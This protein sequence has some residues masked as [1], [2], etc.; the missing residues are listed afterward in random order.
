LAQHPT[1]HPEQD[2]VQDAERW[3]CRIDGVRQCKIDL[4]RHG[5]VAAIHVVA[6]KSREPRHIV[7]D[8]E[9]LLK[10]R[11]DLNVYYKKIGVVQVLD[12]DDLPEAEPAAAEP[13]VEPRVVPAVPPEAVTEEEATRRLSAAAGGAVAAAGN[14]GS[15]AEPDAAAPGP[16]PR[17]VGDPA[18]APPGER[19]ADQAHP[20][21]H[22][23]WQGP[24]P[25]A[26]SPES[27]LETA[28]PAPRVECRGVGVVASGALLTASVELA[29]GEH[30]VRA[31]EQGPH[32]PGLENQ[33]LGR[34]AVTAVRR[35]IADPVT[36][37]L[38]DVREVELAGEPVVCVAV[39]LVE[40]RRR[41]RLF[42]CCSR[43]TAAQLAPVLAVL[44]ALNR[45]LELYEL[46]VTPA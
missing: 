23:G 12:P 16:A 1:D 4:D 39:D 28:A 18:P 41:E 33:L 21:E 26:A 46:V 6:D 25:V 22:A 9:S 8:V 30:I 35:L 11:L 37:N 17:P 32:Q 45:R 27:A 5:E 10:A 43:A 44:D 24:R 14:P 34:A 38:S 2:W 19:G 29:A 7:R 40:G 42:G 31:E 15:A 20:W 13:A 36:L 3:I